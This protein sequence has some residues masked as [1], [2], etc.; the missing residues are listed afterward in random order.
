MKAKSHSKTVLTVVG[1]ETVTFITKDG[2]TI[3]CRLSASELNGR[4]MESIFNEGVYP[5]IPEEVPSTEQETKQEPMLG[6]IT[7]PELRAYCEKRHYPCDNLPMSQIRFMNR[8]WALGEE[9]ARHIMQF[10]YQTRADLT[11]SGDIMLYKGCGADGKSWHANTSTIIRDGKVTEDGHIVYEAN[12]TVV[13]EESS[14]PGWEGYSC[15]CVPGLYAGTESMASGFGSLIFRCSV[16]PEDIRGIHSEKVRATAI[17]IHDVWQIREPYTH[18]SPSV[19]GER[20]PKMFRSIPLTLL[21]RLAEVELTSPILL[22]ELCG[23][24]DNIF[25]IIAALSTMGH[26]IYQKHADIYVEPR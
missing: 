18:Q 5:D 4:T 23:P 17:E 15:A 6:S 25:V 26:R 10:R 3:V 8:C 16:R 21:K 2:N 22:K 19:S 13:A 1:A 11:D 24:E 20:R 12:S 14:I 9:R 7:D